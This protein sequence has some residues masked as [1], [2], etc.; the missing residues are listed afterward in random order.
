MTP[1][2]ALRATALLAALAAPSALPGAALAQTEGTATDATEAA[3]AAREA[4][5]RR[6]YEP[7]SGGSVDVFD[8]VLTEGWSE[9]P[10]PPDLAPGR[11][12]YKENVAGLVAMAPDLSIEVEEVLVEG[13]MAAVR[14]RLSA[15]HAQPMFGVPPT[16]RRFEIMTMDMHRF[17][18]DRIAHTW[19]VE[20][21]LSALQQI[22]AM[23]GEGEQQDEAGAAPAEDATTAGD[24]EMDAL[25]R[26]LFRSADRNGNGELTRSEVSHFQVG[27]FLGMDADEDGAVSEDE[28][29]SYDFGESGLAH[30]RGRRDAVREV[31]RAYFAEIDLNDDDRI[32]VGE[33]VLSFQADYAATDADGDNK[34]SPEEFA[35]GLPILQ[36]MGAALGEP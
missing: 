24:P 13:D 28:F 32:G 34:L 33:Q 20:D 4:T 19:H 12:A 1:R 16:G 30:E 10:A 7:F 31:A 9:T 27:V 11:E 25:A 21:W 8:E 6:F 22:G 17:E 14:S 5:A 36:R 2:S 26:G 15:T 29:T 35:A 23:G 3:R 18:G